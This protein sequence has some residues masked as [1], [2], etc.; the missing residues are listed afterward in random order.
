MAGSSSKGERTFLK[1]GSLRGVEEIYRRVL[2]PGMPGLDNLDRVNKIGIHLKSIH[3][4]PYSSHYRP[5]TTMLQPRFR[6]HPIYENIVFPLGSKHED[7]DDSRKHSSQTNRS[8]SQNSRV[9]SQLPDVPDSSPM[10]CKPV[11]PYYAEKITPV[12]S[13]ERLQRPS[14]VWTFTNQSGRLE[15]EIGA[16]NKCRDLKKTSE[17]IPHRVDRFYFMSGAPKKIH[18]RYDVQDEDLLALQDLAQSRL[19]S[20]TT[21]PS[22]RS[23]PACAPPSLAQSEKTPRRGM[24]IT[25]GLP[26]NKESKSEVKTEENDWPINQQLVETNQAANCN[27]ELAPVNDSCLSQT[28]LV[29]KEFDDKSETSSVASDWPPVKVIHKADNSVN[30][31]N[32]SPQEPFKESESGKS[33]WGNSYIE[34]ELNGHNDEVQECRHEKKANFRDAEKSRV[35]PSASANTNLDISQLDNSMQANLLRSV[36]FKFPGD[37]PLAASPRQVVEVQQSPQDFQPSPCPDNSWSPG[38]VHKRPCVA[39]KVRSSKSATEDRTPV[40][41]GQACKQ[42]PLKDSIKN[43]SSPSVSDQRRYSEPSN[44]TMAI[45]TVTSDGVSTRKADVLAMDFSEERKISQAKDSDDS[46]DSDWDSDS[47]TDW[48][49]RMI[50]GVKSSFFKSDQKLK[51]LRANTS[52]LNA[53]TNSDLSWV[54]TEVYSF[55]SPEQRQVFEKHFRALDKN[56]NGVVSRNELQIRLFENSTQKD[57]DLFVK[58]FDLNKDGTVDMREFVTV[59]ALNDKLCGNTTLDDSKLLKLDLP[60]LAYHITAFKEMF[61]L[62]DTDRDLSLSIQELMLMITVGLSEEIGTDKSLVDVIVQ[63]VDSDRSGRI[64]FVEFLSFIPFFLGIFSHLL[65][66][67]CPD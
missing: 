4:I 38:K 50:S 9:K 40:A 2:T 65:E 51:S 61:D 28:E 29:A 5:R 11:L 55:V 10:T 59:A 6:T 46:D 19:R 37:G 41:N 18:R 36:E 24:Q 31:V 52:H 23:A 27:T 21:T 60:K 43:G 32:S 35:V 14:S 42:Q 12:P 34:V 67:A 39:S 16:L 63:T 53:H 20:R 64:E 54:K 49:M 8:R 13:R 3:M 48:D 44:N 17:I 22:T 57:L 15:R 66:E 33:A 26:V 7:L 58:V 45:F 62:C 30:P 47:L 56:G 1:N 25:G